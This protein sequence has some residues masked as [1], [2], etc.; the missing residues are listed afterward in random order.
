MNYLGP[1]K[2]GHFGFSKENLPNQNVKV[3]F[4]APRLLEQWLEDESI[5]LLNDR[6]IATRYDPVTGK[7]SLLDLGL[8]PKN[9]R[10]DV[11]QFEVD[12]D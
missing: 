12:S 6:S 9:L 4:V 7:G 2:K 11:K 3:F 10:K 8:I 1:L 5:K